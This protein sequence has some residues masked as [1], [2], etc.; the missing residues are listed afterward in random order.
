MHL[1]HRKWWKKSIMLSLFHPCIKKGIFITC[2]RKLYRWLL[3]GYP[4]NVFTTMENE[5]PFIRVEISTRALYNKWF[6]FRDSMRTVPDWS[7]H[8]KAEEWDKHLDASLVTKDLYRRSKAGKINIT[9]DPSSRLDMEAVLDDYARL[10]FIPGL[11][12]QTINEW[13][14]EKKVT[15]LICLA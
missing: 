12:E 11:S 9:R 1:R 3:T 15:T 13:F 7:V 8:I 6:S 4:E 10:L 5:L 2:V 14:S